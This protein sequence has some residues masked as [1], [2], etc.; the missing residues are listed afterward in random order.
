M[1]ADLANQAPDLFAS[2]WDYPLTDPWPACEMMKWVS[3]RTYDAGSQDYHPKWSGMYPTAVGVLVGGPGSLV[4]LPLELIFRIIEDMDVISAELFSRTCTKA[5][6][7]LQSSTTWQKIMA[8]IPQVRYLYVQRGVRHWN[9][10]RAIINELEYSRCRTCSRPADIFFWLTCERV[11]FNCLTQNTGFRLLTLSEATQAY[12]LTP[13]EFASMPKYEHHVSRF[14]SFPEIQPESTIYVAAKSAYIAGIK[15]WGSKEAMIEASRRIS[16]PAWFSATDQSTIHAR[17]ELMWNIS[18]KTADDASQ[19][20]ELY[21]QLRAPIGCMAFYFPC[22][23]PYE[24]KPTQFY[25]CTGCAFLVH[26]RYDLAAQI[27][28][29][30][31]AV[32]SFESLVKRRALRGQARMLLQSDNILE[33]MQSCTGTGFFKKQMNLEKLHPESLGTGLIAHVSGDPN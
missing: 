23:K 7:L 4:K 1:E 22:V 11:C 9:T 13:N 15:L 6:F 32:P 29:M 27:E 18:L 24:K 10:L 25:R 16:L 19:C 17:I 28:A 3:F 31:G 2:E 30:T 8:Y 5:R 12:C 26:Y 20:A 14:S 21:Y 33:H